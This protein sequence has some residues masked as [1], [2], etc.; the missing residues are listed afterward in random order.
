MNGRIL[1]TLMEEQIQDLSV[2]LQMIID[3]LYNYN[4]ILSINNTILMSAMEDVKLIQ[5]KYTLGSASI[6]ELL[7]AQ[8]SELS[9][10]SSI[11]SA[12]YD[13]LIEHANFN[14]LLGKLDSDYK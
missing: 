1:M 4:E 9:A 7:D 12:R 11:I 13:A 5:E 8:V 10:R 3:R 14:A 2:R 6:L